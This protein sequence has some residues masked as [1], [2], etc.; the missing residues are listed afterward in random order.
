MLHWIAKTYLK[1]KIAGDRKVHKQHSMA[2][3]KV[4]RIALIL[5]KNDKINKSEMDKLLDSTKKFIEVFYIELSSKTATYADWTSFLKT[6]KSLLGLPKSTVLDKLKSK[7][8]DVVINAASDNHLYAAAI[9]THLPAP[10]KSS[11]GNYYNIGDLIIHKQTT[12]TTTSYLNQ[13][14]TY[15]KMIR[16]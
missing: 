12:D 2:W 7:K 8:F 10:C 9:A 1:N 3:D 11:T 5:D 15:L 16:V 14:V 13:V 6:D 4:E